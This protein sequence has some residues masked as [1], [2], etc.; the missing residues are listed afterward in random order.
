LNYIELKFHLWEGDQKNDEKII[1]RMFHGWPKGL[2]Y[3]KNHI[4]RHKNNKLNKK[5]RN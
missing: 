1:M 2:Q 4:Y 3:S 5:K